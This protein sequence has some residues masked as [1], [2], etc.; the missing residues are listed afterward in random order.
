MADDSVAVVFSASIGQLI[1]GVAEVKQAILSIADPIASVASTFGALGESIAAAFAVEK[2]AGFFENLAEGATQTAKIAQV[3]GISNGAVGELDVAAKATGT[4]VEAFAKSLERL[5]LNLAKGAAGSAQQ[6]AALNALGISANQLIGLPLAER[7]ALVADKFSVLHDGIDKDAIGIALFG[8]QFDNL[9]PFLNRG[10]EG[11]KEFSDI[12]VRSGLKAALDETTPGFER[13]HILLVELGSAT[14]A[15]AKFAGSIFKPAFD[16]VVKVLIDLTEA[17]TQSVRE[18]G[19]MRVL[20]NTL[21]QGC[22]IFEIAI[23]SGGVA[24]AELWAVT[25]QTVFYIGESF[26]DLGRIIKDVLTFNWSDVSAAWNDLGKQLAAR[27]AMT[28]KEMIGAWQTA[29][30]EVKTILGVGADEALKIEQKK[31]SQLKLAIKDIVAAELAAA[32]E[33]IKIAD[34]A[35]AQTAERLNSEYKQA[36][37]TESQKTQALLAALEV[38]HAAETAAVGEELAV[39]N[40][41]KAQYQKVLNE[42]LQ[43]DQKYASDRQKIIDQAAEAEA[44]TWKSAADQI[45]GALSSQNKALLSGQETLAQAMKNISADLILKLIADGEKWAIEWIAAQLRTAVMGTALKTA[46]VATTT[47]TETAKTTAVV[48]GASARATAETTGA[49]VG[50]LAQI[51]NALAVIT[52][53]AA[54]TFAGVFAFLAPAMGPAAAGP[55]ASSAAAVEASA[56]G[57]AVPGLSVGTDYVLSPGLAMLHSGE[58]VVPAS[59]SGP[60]TGANAGGGSGPQIS[61]IVQALDA[62][63]VQKFFQSNA[64]QISRVLSSHMNAN[65]SF[66]QA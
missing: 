34:M 17:F 41:S 36:Q 33:K 5:G 61:F 50:I 55:A 11:I 3:L 1:E 6:A 45:A 59:T 4:S 37:I 20:M 58:Q 16:G 9:L 2:I 46:D 48:T 66:N 65:P 26:K 13:T 22:Q 29:V 53:D 28:A 32:Q 24:I 52:A 56:A 23:V 25:K 21:V 64:S 39:A 19:S 30:G 35:Y 18:G 15:A 7:M 10:S 31:N 38:R 40:Q 54:K 8:R 42:K 47:A 14:D 60:Y 51:G 27:N 44:K 49:S 62:S 57:V 63:S 43:L 12:A